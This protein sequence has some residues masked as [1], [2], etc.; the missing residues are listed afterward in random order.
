MNNQL[1]QYSKPIKQE[2]TK[3]STIYW[4]NFRDSKKGRLFMPIYDE[5]FPFVF[6]VKYSYISKF[7]EKGNEAGNHYHNVKEEI[8]IP[9]Q[10]SFDI[11][12][13]DTKTKEKEVISLNGDDNKG[14]Y[15]RTGIYHKV[16][17]KDNTGLLLVLA[18]NHSTLADEIEY[19]VE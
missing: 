14:I 19:V 3:L 10:G 7:L 2:D 4:L 8:L 15:I 16:V 12:L 5:R 6:K 17:S 1:D 11:F 9:L 13:E 18:S